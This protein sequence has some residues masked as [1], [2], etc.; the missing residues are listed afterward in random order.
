MDPIGRITKAD[1]STWRSCGISGVCKSTLPIRSTLA[2]VYPS[3][4]G[5]RSAGFY[6]TVQRPI[7]AYVLLFCPNVVSSNEPSTG[8][9]IARRHSKDSKRTTES[10]EAMI[11]ITMIVLMTRRLA[12]QNS[13]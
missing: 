11:Y 2:A 3:G 6:K 4:A 8:S 9:V 5:R 1:T 10:S 13:I 7:V 12:R